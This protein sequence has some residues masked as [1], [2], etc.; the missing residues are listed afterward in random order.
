MHLGFTQEIPKHMDN[1][2]RT[3]D[4]PED[5]TWTT[6]GSI[7]SEDLDPPDYRGELRLER[8]HRQGSASC[9][10]AARCSVELVELQIV[11][12][13][14][15]IR[16]YRGQAPRVMLPRRPVQTRSGWVR[17]HYSL[18]TTRAARQAFADEVLRLILIADP[19]LAEEIAGLILQENQDALNA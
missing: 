12:Q 7:G 15:E 13:A 9:L 8:W 3:S 16:L 5:E 10:L 4:P 17:G 18:F 2:Y 19:Q 11:L 14:I 6:A 1:A